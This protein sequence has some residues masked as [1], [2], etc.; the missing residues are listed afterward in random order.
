MGKETWDVILTFRPLLLHPQDNTIQ[1]LLLSISQYDDVFSDILVLTNLFILF[2]L[3]IFEFVMSIHAEG[4]CQFLQ[5]R[6]SA[7]TQQ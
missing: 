3:F 1:V 5:Y 4:P 2:Y 6:M 7:D